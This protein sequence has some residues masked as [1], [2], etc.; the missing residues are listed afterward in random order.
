[1]IDWKKR[2]SNPLFIIEIVMAILLP[3]ISYMGLTLE[4]LNS[5]TMLFNVLKDGLLNPY[6]I[7]VMALSVFNAVTDPTTK[8]IGDN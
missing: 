2:F 5:W 1:M 8:G 4:D 7:G 3:L 6:V